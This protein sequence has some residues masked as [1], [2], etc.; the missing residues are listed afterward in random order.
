MIKLMEKTTQDTDKRLAADH[1]KWLTELL[2][3]S[4]DV[5][6]NITKR[7]ME[8]EFIHGFKHGVEH[9]RERMKRDV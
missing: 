1:V 2:G 6:M 8:E 7:L 3:F 5:W 9:E 4:F